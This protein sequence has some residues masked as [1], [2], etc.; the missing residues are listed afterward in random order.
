VFDNNTEIS[1]AQ[2][3]RM[4]SAEINLRYWVSMPPGPFDVSILVGG[5]YMNLDDRFRVV[6][7]GDGGVN[8]LLVETENELWGLQLGIQGSCLKTTRYWID[9]DLKGGIYSN[10]TTVFYDLIAAG[11]APDPTFEGEAN[12]TTFV[13]DISIVG[14]WQMTPWLVFNLGYQ[15]IFVDG[16]ALGLSNAENPPFL[17]GIDDPAT[18]QFDDS[19]R[20]LFHGPTIGLMGV[21]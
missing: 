1:V 18:T 13:G 8:D 14:H 16:V 17:D 7:T 10:E 12:R 6:S 9:F 19:G 5:R 4:S 20:I 2:A 15:A 21:W 11:P 3:T